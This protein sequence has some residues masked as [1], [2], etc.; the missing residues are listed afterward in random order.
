MAVVSRTSP[1]TTSQFHAA[2]SYSAL[3]P[4]VDLVTIMTYDY[5][6][7][8]GGAGPVAPVN[9]QER[10]MNYAVPLFGANKI[11]LG[12]PFY[13]YDWNLTKE[14]QD[15]SIRAVSRTFDETMA[16]QRDNNGTFGWETASATPFLNYTKDGDEHVV[17]F[18]NARSLNAKLDMMKR[19][20]LRGFAAWRLGHEGNEFWSPIK[21]LAVPTLRVPKP[22][23]DTG[24]RRYFNETGHTLSGTFKRYWEQ[25][26]GLPVFGYPWT[27]EFVEES[28]SEAGKS[29]TVQ[30]FERN[31]FEYHPEFAGTRYE[32]LLGLLG[33]Q[34]TAGREDEV[35]FRRV[36]NPNQPGVD[37]YPETGHTLRG[38][39]KDYWYT[40]GG[41]WL[42][43]YPISEQFEERNPDDG[44]TYVV[45]Y[46]ER[47]R[48]EYHPEKAGT[49]Y[50]VLLGLLGNKLMRD[51]GWLQ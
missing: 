21:N 49:K 34:L 7:S 44:K 35:P 8:G 30:Y 27:E 47:N 3:A 11:L 32:V 10:V 39:F 36:E 22:G 50:E 2:Y 40:N 51:K 23:P 43:G 9:W 13:G 1:T 19:Q 37:F 17:Y 41:L 31:R 18:E 28:P 16:L 45:Q 14:K 5:H 48:F 46:F 12:I 29:F 42:F 15:S 6:Y 20:N 38:K 33:R 26:G 4:W 24:F 25:Y